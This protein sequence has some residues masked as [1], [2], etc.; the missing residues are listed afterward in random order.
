MRK[1]IKTTTTLDEFAYIIGVL[2]S[3][4]C[5]GD[6]AEIGVYNGGSAQM[7]REISDGK[8]YLFDTFTGIIG[9]QILDYENYK[10]GEYR[11]PVEEVKRNLSDYKDIE[12]YEG[13]IFRTKSLVKRKKFKFIHIDLDIYSPL[14]NI[15]DFF[16]DRLLKGG[17]MI[18]SNHDDAHPGVI[19]AVKEFDKPFKKYSRL[20]R[21]E[22]SN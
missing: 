18:I 9:E 20:I 2:H 17:V 1:A 22:K 3:L 11:C 8:L 12:Y 5:K 7:I 21:Y 19:K 16:Y 10:D 15:L 14:Q 6:M 13:D 4:N